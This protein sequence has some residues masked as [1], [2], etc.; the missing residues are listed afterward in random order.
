MSLYMAEVEQAPSKVCV[1]QVCPNNSQYNR[2]SLR[3]LMA[4]IARTHKRCSVRVFDSLAYHSYMANGCTQDDALTRSRRR[5]QEW[6]ERY[7]RYQRRSEFQGVLS[8][9]VIDWDQIKQLPSFEEKTSLVNW[10]YQNTE[11][12]AAVDRYVERHITQAI[13]EGR[14]GN[15]VGLILDSSRAYI[16]EELAGKSAMLADID[17]NRPYEIYS[18]HNALDP[19]LFDRVSQKYNINL[20]VHKYLNMDI[21]IQAPALEVA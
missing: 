20:R 1:L 4:A 18:G 13:A 5:G 14:V 9:E 7:L 2:A 19:S 17:Q 8:P 16:L 15:E 11:V 6:I 21:Y 12:G 3:A 10:A